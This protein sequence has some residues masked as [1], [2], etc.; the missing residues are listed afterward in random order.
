MHLLPDRVGRLLPSR[1]L[2]H[3]YAGVLAD[4]D[5]LGPHFLDHVGALAAQEIEPRL[6]GGV[7]LR[8]ELR[9]GQ[10][11]QLGL[12][13]VHADAFGERRVDLH[14][15][16]R[17][18]A[19]PLGVLHEMQRAHVV[20]PVGQLHQQHADVAADR[21]HQLAEILRLLGAVG[22]Q[23]QP[24]QLGDAID[25]PGDLAAEPRLDLRQLDRRILDHVVQQPGGDRGGIQP[26]ARQDVGHRERMRDVGIAVVAA[27][28]AVRPL[29]QRIGGVDQPGVRLGIVARSLPPDCRTRPTGRRQV[30]C[31]T[32]PPPPHRQA[33]RRGRGGRV[34]ALPAPPAVMRGYRAA[35]AQLR[36]DRRLEVLGRHLFAFDGQGRRLFLG[37]HVLQAED[38]LVGRDEVQHLLVRGLRLRRARQRLDQVLLDPAELDRLVGDL[39]QRDDG[40]LV[41][42][43][44]DGQ[45]L[46]A[47]QVARTLG[48]E[49]NELEAVRDLL[50]AIFDGD[51]RHALS[52]QALGLG[53]LW[54]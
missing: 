32:P 35:A 52:L 49:Q 25:Q 37:R 14:R 22:L 16:A 44:V 45:F 6:D 51:A 1:D 18:P 7:R 23:L 10:R 4:A 48:G 17:D 15:L 2:D 33:R 42:V 47:A 9:E 40:V 31:G 30:P 11:L 39:A 12:H 27:L 53:E 43:A 28:R 46:A 3:L 13:R 26:I 24:G 54:M 50:D 8:I 21:Q 38:V 41:V 36:L 29:G 19:A 20:Q 5:E 34:P